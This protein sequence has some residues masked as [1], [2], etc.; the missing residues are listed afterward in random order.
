LKRIVL[1]LVLVV[2]AGLTSLVA[3]PGAQAHDFHTRFTHVYLDPNGTII[4]YTAIHHETTIY[5]VSLAQT[6]WPLSQNRCDQSITR[7]TDSSG[8]YTGSWSSNS[9]SEV[10]GG[11]GELYNSAHRVKFYGWVSDWFN[12]H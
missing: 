12:Y 8:T 6:T 9:D 10:V 5:G 4:C 7:V 11:F 2:C 1:G 3:A